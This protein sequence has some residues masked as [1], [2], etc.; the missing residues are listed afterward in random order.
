MKI[1]KSIFKDRG[2]QICL[3]VIALQQI[4][5]AL[6]TF[7]MGDLAAHVPTEGLS[8]FKAGLL[9]FSLVLSGSLFHVLMK[10]YMTVAQK[11]VLWKYFESYTRSNYSRPD[12]WRSSQAKSE[13]HD[14]MMREGQDSISSSVQF[15][16]DSVATSFN[17]LFNTVSVILVTST[18]MGI[19]IVGAG[20]L[21][22]LV[23]HIAD[24]AITEGA[25]KE[26][27][28]QN[29]VNGF[30]AKSWDNI[31]LGNRSTF[32]RWTANFNA[33]FGKSREASLQNIR[34]NDGVVGIA[35][36]LTSFIVVATVFSLIYLH[37]NDTAKVVALLVMLPRSMQI[38]MHI[39]VIQSY[40][41]HWKYLLQRLEMTEKTMAYAE[42]LRLADFIKPEKIQVNSRNQR[43]T[44]LE[45]DEAL[46]NKTGRITVTGA[47]GAGKSTLLLKL[48]QNLSE[49]GFYIP[50]HHQLELSTATFSKSSGEVAL[51]ALEDATKDQARVIL[52]DEW[53]ANLSKEN[54]LK[55]DRVIEDLS[56]AKLIVEIRHHAPVV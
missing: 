51:C 8:F 56:R 32:E 5:V 24:K 41:A 52:L 11:G 27:T 22:L 2:F 54:Q 15:A 37:Q 17:I 14:I 28:A 33:L 45:L 19:S 26:M 1:A 53:D 9:L 49:E 4:L 13:R 42:E 6:G 40:W 34:V 16:A 50:S 18:V 7:L 36:F 30:L 39:Q 46:A 35:A 3:L 55:L 23:V 47:N 25:Q 20:I 48:K 29:E 21:G 10:Y 12:L 38:V 31:I 44:F 43:I